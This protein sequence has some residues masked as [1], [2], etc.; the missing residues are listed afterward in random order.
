MNSDRTSSPSTFTSASAFPIPSPTE[1]AVEPMDRTQSRTPR[2]MTR[3]DIEGVQPP[4]M[5]RIAPEEIGLPRSSAST[6]S[7]LSEAEQSL[8]PRPKYFAV[9][10]DGT[11]TA[12]VAVDE[13]PTSL[14]IAGVPRTL[15][16]GETTG[17][18]SVGI[19]PRANGYYNAAMELQS[20]S[21]HSQAITR[22][23]STTTSIYQGQQIHPQG[24]VERWVQETSPINPEVS[25]PFHSS[26]S[27][28]FLSELKYNSQPLF[29]LQLPPLAFRVKKRC[30]GQSTPLSWAER[31]TVLTGYVPANATSCN[32]GASTDMKCPMRPCWRH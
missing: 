3:D 20:P 22:R 16:P 23:D 5:E 26:L 8:S 31:F 4:A 30:T 19:V 29:P 13:L 25:D 21:A 10:S 24:N 14:R 32:K 6:V 11:L 1:T 7:D 18:I 15:S 12:L 17:M 9:R 28:V 2:A 27:Y